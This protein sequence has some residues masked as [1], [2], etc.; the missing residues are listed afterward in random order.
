MAPVGGPGEPAVAGDDQFGGE[1]ARR[2][3]PGLVREQ[4]GLPQG[5]QRTVPGVP[6]ADRD[7]RVEF[8]DDIGAVAVGVEG[9]MARAAAG[10][11]PGLGVYGQRPLGGQGTAADRV[12]AQVD[13]EQPAAAGVGQHGVGV[14][15]L[16]AVGPRAAAPVGE[17][18]GGSGERAV[19]P[20]GERTE[21]AGAVVG[22]DETAA[23]QGEVGGVGAVHGDGGGQEFRSPAGQGEGGCGAVRGLADRVEVPAVGARGQVGGVGDGIR[24]VQRGECAG[25]RVNGRRGDAEAAGRG[26][27]SDVRP[28]AVV[29]RPH[30]SALRPPA[31]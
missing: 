16:L 29:A 10:P 23:G 28:S 12:G 8:V 13:A 9:E 30:W 24:G 15:A 11:Q 25:V 31:R 2:I 20:Y 4:A 22:G 17:H 7:R 19:G 26:E 18:G 27:R 1:G 5:G 21:A 6:A 3:R 14:R